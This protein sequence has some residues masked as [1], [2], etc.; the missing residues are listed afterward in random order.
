MNTVDIRLRRA[1]SWGV[2][3]GGRPDLSTPRLRLRRWRPSDREPFAAINSDP[4]VTRYLREPLERAASDALVE[5]IEAGFDRD[6]FG[7]WA[8]ELRSSGGFLGFT[9]LTRPGFDAPFTP[10]VEIGW[11]LARAAWG[12]GYAIEAAH[13]ALGFGFGPA[14][15]IEV[16]SMTTR[17]NERSRAVMR[18]LGMTCDPGDDFDHPMLPADHPLRPHVL[19]RLTRPRWQLDEDD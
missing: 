8:L 1:G 19:Y 13:A 17:T 3:H 12:H 11:R 10:A 14:G 5:R 2:E 15:L 6:G 16:V 9:G 18:R 7:L 4:E